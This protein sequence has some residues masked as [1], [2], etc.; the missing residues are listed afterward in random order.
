MTDNKK[1][2][3]FDIELF[4][5]VMCPGIPVTEDLTIEVEFF[6]EEVAKIRQLVKDYTG[7]KGAGLMPILLND[8]P[9]LHERIA[10]AA[11][12][13]IYDFY[14]LDGLRNDY[15]ELD[16]AD[17]RR[18]FKQD[19]ESGEFNPAE[20]IEESGWC[21]EVP[22]DDDDLFYLW[23]VWER[24]QFSFCDVAWALARYPDLPDHMDLEDNQDYICSIPDAFNS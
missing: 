13:E 19:L 2:I 18:N 1:T 21:D 24:D 4:Q 17:K 6:D 14:L 15:I 9:E 3:Q 10:K 7:D 12:K 8:A 16:E 11:F 22:S 5:G 23:E 20:Y